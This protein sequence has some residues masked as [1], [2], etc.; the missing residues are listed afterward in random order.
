MITSSET[1]SRA[2]RPQVSRLESPNP[3]YIKQLWK[4]IADCT[5]ADCTVADCTVAECTIAD[6]T[7]A[8]CT[9]AECTIVDCTGT[10]A[11]CALA[12]TEVERWFLTDC[13]QRQPTC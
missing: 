3:T 9:I 6:F 11:D 10:D 5:V 2:E 7:M 12:Y 4:A 1:F 8:D 13:R